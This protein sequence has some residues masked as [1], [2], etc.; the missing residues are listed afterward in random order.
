MK[1]FSRPTYRINNAP[2]EIKW[3]YT[4]FL[5]FMI[6]GFATIGGYEFRQIG[7]HA[8]AVIEH[9]RG[10]SEEGMVFPKS[11]Q[12]LLETTHFHAFIMGVI[13]LT[14]AHL[15]LAT[16]VS[17]RM[18]MSLVIVGFIC[19]FLDLLLPWAV[20]YLSSRF[21]PVLLAAWVGE[22]VSYMAMI[23]LSLYDLWMRPRPSLDDLEEGA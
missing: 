11:F 23:L 13:Y 8:Q 12:T 6:V 15:F 5:I 16:E 17:R 2:S 9:Y 22:W 4:F 3:V 20:R 7:F 10:S 1:S 18:K 19:T 21:A 14:L